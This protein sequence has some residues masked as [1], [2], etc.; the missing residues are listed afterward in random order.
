MRKLIISTTTMLLVALPAFAAQTPLWEK[1]I[2]VAIQH[3]KTN[4]PDAEIGYFLSMARH[5]AWSRRQEFV[6]LVAPHLK[7]TEPVKVAGALDVLHWLRIYHPM[8]YLGDFQ[9]ENHDFFADID[10]IV[11]KRLD[12]LHSLKSDRVYH[13]LAIYLGS[14]PTTESKRHL[15]KTV[16]S[17]IA[18]HAK[19][20][21]LI[22]LTWHRDPNDM[23]SLLPFMLEDSRASRSLPYHFR[24]SYGQASVPYL[25]KALSDA[26][27]PVTRLKAAFELVHLRIPDGFRYLHN[28]ALQDPPPEAKRSRHLERIKQFATDYLGLPRGASSK[29][30]IAAHLEKK[31][32]ELCKTER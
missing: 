3:I 30:D 20:Q 25:T 13:T 2:D 8:T 26:K 24:N 15:L 10:R 4:G 14:S 29:D 7:G 6:D 22:S 23:Q 28:V 12:H 27:S 11:Y 17:P 1:L 32:R 19:E 9:K 21:A 18:K 16:K 5:H 31:Q